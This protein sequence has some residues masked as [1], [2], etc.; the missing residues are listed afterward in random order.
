MTKI[1]MHRSVPVDEQRGAVVAR[2]AGVAGVIARTYG[3]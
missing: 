1:G 2:V 3:I